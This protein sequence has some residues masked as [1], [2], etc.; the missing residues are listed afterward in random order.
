MNKIAEC[1]GCLDIGMNISKV[2][3]GR[4]SLTNFTVETLVDGGIYGLAF[5]IGI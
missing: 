3:A 2:E 1:L 4:M 5:G